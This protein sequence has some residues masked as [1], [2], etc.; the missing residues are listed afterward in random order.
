MLA[1]RIYAK[2]DRTLAMSLLR[3]LFLNMTGFLYY[4]P[5]RSPFFLFLVVTG[6]ISQDYY[7]FVISDGFV[8]ERDGKPVLL[9]KS[10][11]VF[12]NCCL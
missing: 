4:F 3:G 6:Y 8:F 10:R 7:Y 1:W 11:P 12:S 2:F 9:Q 5:H